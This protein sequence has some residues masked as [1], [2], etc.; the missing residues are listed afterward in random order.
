MEETL[1]ESAVWNRVTA[2]SRSDGGADAGPIGPELL[3][4]LERQR[5][6]AYAC[7]ALL[8]CCGSDSRQAMRQLVSLQLQQARG[9]SALYFFLTGQRPCLPERKEPSRRETLSD[10]LRRVMQAS[11]LHAGRLEALAG[12]STG[13]VR[14]GLGDLC[15]RE[16]RCFHQM[17]AL[18]GHILN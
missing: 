18:L 2:A 11:E 9:L 4:A 12:R 17:L 14:Q 15:L 10:G 3:A 6:M 16:R 13:E 1:N 7:R 8:G 5:D